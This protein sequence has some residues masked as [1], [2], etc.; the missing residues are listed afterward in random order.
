ML[1]DLQTLSLQGSKKVGKSA[2]K[3]IHYSGTSSIKEKTSYKLSTGQ[4]A[5]HTTRKCREVASDAQVQPAKIRAEHI[6]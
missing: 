1:H 5:A 4:G 6:T 3:P 2:A